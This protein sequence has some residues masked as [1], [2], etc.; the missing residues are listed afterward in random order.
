MI[1]WYAPDFGGAAAQSFLLD[2]GLET[3]SI[4]ILVSFL[5]C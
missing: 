3:E 5:N 1:V 4:W 2:T